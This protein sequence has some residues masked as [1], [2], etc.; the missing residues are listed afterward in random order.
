MV[1]TSQDSG[2]STEGLRLGN[3]VLDRL[4]A[5]GEKASLRYALQLLTPASILAGLAGRPT[6]EVEDV[7]E[8][9]ELFLDAKSSAAMIGEDGGFGG[10]R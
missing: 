9:G 8:M 3:S 2:G 6:I 10:R 7:G 4:A 5:D 1:P